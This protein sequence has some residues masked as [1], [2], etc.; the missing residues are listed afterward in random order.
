M[1]DLDRFTGSIVA[2]VTPMKKTSNHHIIDYIKF[3]QL[4][5]WHIE[6]GTN[7]V[8][9][10]GSTGEAATLEEDEWVKL[11][12]IAKDTVESVNYKRNHISNKKKLTIIAGTGTNCTNATIKKTCIAEKIG[13]DAALVVTPYYNKPTQQGLLLH[14]S[15]LAKKTNLPIILYNVPSRT[16]CDLLPSTVIELSKIYNIIGIKEATGKLDKVTELKSLCEENF[17]L[18]SGD[19]ISFLEFMSLGGKGV[20]SVTA[21]VIPGIM[22]Q[23]CELMLSH[24]SD[25][26]FIAKKMNVQLIEL[27]KAL[28]IESNPIPVKWLLAY[29]EK[30]DEVYRLPLTKLSKQ[31]QEIIID[32]YQHAINNIY[33]HME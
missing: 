8:V 26:V 6:E 25:D 32:A 18:L 10:A 11:L 27:H 20:I 21:N 4:I 2:L 9:I 29:L 30:I 33:L 12:E 3:Q 16:G 14:Y 28:M 24:K 5:A 31:Y 1:Y 15:E 19:D 7:G 13:I 22:R 23:I 17:V